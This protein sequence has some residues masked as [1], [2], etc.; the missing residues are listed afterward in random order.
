MART[1]YFERS[2]K[3]ESTKE[4]LIKQFLPAARIAIKFGAECYSGGYTKMNLH[5]RL[6]K[7]MT[8]RWKDNLQEDLES[9]GL[10]PPESTIEQK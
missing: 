4:L 9:Y 6:G 2:F 3:N 7:S 1:K 10:V 5:S 8:Q